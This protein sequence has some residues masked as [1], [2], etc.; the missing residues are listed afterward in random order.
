MT[1]IPSKQA[2]NED[3]AFLFVLVI[4]TKKFGCARS[5]R[6]NFAQNQGKFSSN[7]KSASIFQNFAKIWPQNQSPKFRGWEENFKYRSESFSIVQV[8]F[9]IVQYRSSIV[10]NRSV[11][12]KYRSES[13]SIVQASFRIVQNRSVSFK[14]RSESF[15]IV[16]SF[17]ATKNPF[18][19]VFAQISP[20][21][22]KLCQKLEFWAL[23]AIACPIWSLSVSGDF[24]L[25]FFFRKTRMTMSQ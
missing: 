20:P 19:N 2:K 22:P 23:R 1:R 9:R 15:N 4:E 24:C 17:R 3:F 8:S 5:S 6:P 13:F 10:Q 14:Y 21:I 11:S 18:W 16:Q 25:L 7:N 12:F